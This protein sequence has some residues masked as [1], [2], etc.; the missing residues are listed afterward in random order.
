MMPFMCVSGPLGVDGSTPWRWLPRILYWFC[1]IGHVLSML[2]HKGACTCRTEWKAF[3]RRAMSAK[4]PIFV[5]MPS[6]LCKC[7]FWRRVSFTHPLWG[8]KNVK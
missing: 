5:L 7:K 2:C 4:N 1:D 8:E 6:K 3:E